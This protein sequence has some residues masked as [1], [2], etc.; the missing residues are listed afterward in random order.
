MPKI[1]QD[2][3]KD[4]PVPLPPREEQE[5]ILRKM[6]GLRT[7]IQ[8]T[9]SRVSEMESRMEALESSLLADAFAGLT[10]RVL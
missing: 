4:T 3:L 7:P 1:N 10:R 9:S 5:L 2:V 6:D 8:I